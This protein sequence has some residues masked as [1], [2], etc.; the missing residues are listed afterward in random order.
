MRARIFDHSFIES[1]EIADEAKVIVNAWK[2]YLPPTSINKDDINLAG[3]AQIERVRRGKHVSFQSACLAIV[4]LEIAISKAGQTI[5]I[6][7]HVVDDLRHKIAI[8]PT[9]FAVDNFDKTHWDDDTKRKF[10][11][12]LSKATGQTRLM[13][14][15]RGRTVFDDMAE[16]YVVSEGLTSRV[17]DFFKPQI[18]NYTV[19]RPRNGH[20]F[21]EKSNLEIEVFPT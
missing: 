12:D 5:D 11:S 13:S 4:A 9:L 20:V 10:L 14:G 15:S 17:V 7:E 6:Y 1:R 19:C 2:Q 16:G 18:K 8:V 3:A 21:I